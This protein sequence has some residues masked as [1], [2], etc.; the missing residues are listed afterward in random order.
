MNGEPGERPSHYAIRFSAQADQD[1]NETLLRLAD[2]NGNPAARDW[3]D[4]LLEEVGTLAQS[5]RRF[6]LDDHASRRLKRETR[7]LL[8][9]S[10]PKGAAYHVYY[11]VQDESADGPR[12]TVLH[13]RHAARRPITRK[14]A[15]GI[16]ENE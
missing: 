1:V 15:R 10:A 4:R 11:V 2:I 13:I 7:R 9:R 14:E 5:P 6:A 12:V 16:L 3:R 8:Y